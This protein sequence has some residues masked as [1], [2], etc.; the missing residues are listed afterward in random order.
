[1]SH[2]KEVSEDLAG[3]V[4]EL[5][6]DIAK[7]TESVSEIVRSRAS[8]TVD[9]VTDGVDNARQKI[10]SGAAQAQHQLHGAG[11]DVMAA[12]DRNP[13]VAMLMALSAGLL[14]GMMNGIRK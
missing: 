6:N 2:I 10:A 14:I 7:L 11:A 13:L 9:K 8:E 5:R 3:D 1:M 12:I 4:A